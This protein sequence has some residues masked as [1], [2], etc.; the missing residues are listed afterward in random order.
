[1]DVFYAQESETRLSKTVAMRS[2][3]TRMLNLMTY[4]EL[5]ILKDQ[6]TELLVED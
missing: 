5:L 6:L 4:R 2:E 1:M 3:I